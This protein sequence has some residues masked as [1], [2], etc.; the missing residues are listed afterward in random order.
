MSGTFDSMVDVLGIFFFPEIP[1]I[2]KW[3]VLAVL[4]VT[5]CALQGC[6]AAHLHPELSL[7]LGGERE[8]TRTG[9]LGSHF[10]CSPAGVPHSHRPDN[11]CA[12]PFP[13]LYIKDHVPGN[14]IMI[15]QIT[16]VNPIT[17][18]AHSGPASLMLSDIC[19]M[20]LSM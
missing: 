17:D 18:L 16:L 4:V 8:N 5:L 9:A 10:S 7:Q 2:F 3:L 6:V 1:F 13:Y 20:L 11:L 15:N 19:V 14:V 12:L